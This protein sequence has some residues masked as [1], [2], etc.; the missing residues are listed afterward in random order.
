MLLH[1]PKLLYHY[2]SLLLSFPFS[3]FYGLVLWGWGLR[4]NNNKDVVN[5]PTKFRMMARCTNSLQPIKSRINTRLLS[6]QG[7]NL[8]IL[9]Q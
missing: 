2:Y 4:N 9:Y 6:K 5:G 8:T 1:W 7:V 3:S